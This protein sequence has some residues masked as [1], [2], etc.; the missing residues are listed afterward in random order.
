MKRI[1]RASVVVPSGNILSGSVLINHYPANVA[2]FGFRPEMLN[3]KK[4]P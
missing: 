3:I 1:I 4:I 2:V